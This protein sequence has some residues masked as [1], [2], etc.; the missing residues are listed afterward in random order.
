MYVEVW[1]MLFNESIKLIHTQS[2]LRHAWLE[3][4]PHAVI[5]HHFDKNSKAFL[6]WHLHQQQTDDK[7]SPLAVTNLP[8]HQT[9]RKRKL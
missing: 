8:T 1:H 4:L 6:F 5:L 9:I 2:K 3:H 7:G